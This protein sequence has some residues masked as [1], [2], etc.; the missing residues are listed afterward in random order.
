MKLLADQF[1][2]DT[3][4]KVNVYRDSS[5]LVAQRFLK[6][7]QANQHVCDIVDIGDLQFLAD[8]ANRG[9][10]AD[11]SGVPGVSDIRK[12][13]ILSKYYVLENQQAQ[14]CSYN[15][16]QVKGDLI[17]KSWA[18][19]TKPEFKGKIAMADPRN[20]VD[21][22]GAFLLG[23]VSKYGWEWLEA[24]GKQDIQFSPSAPPALAK[25]ASGDVMLSLPTLAQ[26]V[27]TYAEK[28]A[29]VQI[30]SPPLAPTTATP[31]AV[32]VAKTSANP[33]AAVAWTTYCLGVQGQ[34]TMNVYK[35]ISIGVS[36]LGADKV[37][38][39]VAAFGDGVIYTPGEK[40]AQNQINKIAAALNMH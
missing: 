34:T 37:P 18:D 3:G 28:N 15:T 30:V 24:M 6:E 17:P 35:D 2:K 1:T 25:V 5:G 16:D 38:G 9:Y 33:D 40:D 7:Q 26:N 20:N 12:D 32:A 21:T 19:L 39:S 36:A 31:R 14:T 13:W 22:T 8:V 11:I 23:I 29:P 27:V 4:V 10:L